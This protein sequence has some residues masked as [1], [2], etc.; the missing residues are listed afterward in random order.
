MFN[1]LKQR[2]EEPE[3][4][5]DFSAGGKDLREALQHLRRLNRMLGA[6][7]ATLFGVKRLWFEAGKPKQFSILDIGS[8]SGDLNRPILRWADRNNI[9]LRIVLSDLSGEACEAARLLYQDEPRIRVVQRDLFQ[10][11]ERCTDVVTATQF[12]HHFSSEDVPKVIRQMLDASRIGVVIHDIHRHWMPWLAVY[13][14]TRLVSRNRYIRHDGPLSVAKGFRSA[15]W[16]K[17]KETDGVPSLS[18]FWRPLFRYVVIVQ[19]MTGTDAFRPVADG[20]D[21]GGTRL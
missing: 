1:W 7:P 4:M 15:E 8:G 5:D 18:Y 3:F 21:N 2:A 14:V 17:L 19:K 10:L 11:P 20:V 13:I 6:A 12:V 16:E 9:R